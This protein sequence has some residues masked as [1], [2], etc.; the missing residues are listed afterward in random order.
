MSSKRTKERKR[1]RNKQREACYMR[2]RGKCYWCGEQMILRGDS[3]GADY[4]TWE[5]L[6]PR[7]QGGNGLEENTVLA[8]RRC[9]QERG[10]L[11]PAVYRNKKQQKEML[12]RG[13]HPS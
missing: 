6:I 7:S 9:N 13:E 10:T 11:P 8:H 4:A 12:P 2:Q 1:R 3:T 5:H